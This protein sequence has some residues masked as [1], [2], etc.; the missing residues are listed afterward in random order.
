M[1]KTNWQDPK[2]SEVRSTHISGLQEAVGK[3]EESI[4][5]E[6]IAETNIPLS[7][8]YIAE[9]DRYRIFQAPEGKRNW[10]NSPAPVIKKN[11]S[12]IT[13]DFEIDYGGGAIVFTTPVLGTDTLT[14]DVTYTKK[15]EGKGLS[16]NDYT[17]AEKNK[18]AGIEADFEVHLADY[19][20]QVPYG[21][22]TG[23]ANTYAVTL[24]PAPSAYTDGMALA[25]KIN[26]DNTGA[27][28]IN[29]NGLGA[30]SI[31]KSNGN[32]VSSG[33]L[34]AGSIYTLRYNGTNFI[35]QGEGGEYGTATPDKVL[36]GYTIGTEE[37]IKTGTMPNH[38]SKTF[39]P[40]DTTQTS[41]AGYYSGVTVNPRPTLSGNATPD[42]VLAGRTFYNN[43]YTRRT[44][45]LVIPIP[46]SSVWTQRT[47]S[48]D[49]TYIQGVAYGNNMFVVVG[50]GGKLATSTDGITWTQRT[51]S[52][53]T[54]YIQDVAYG[55]NMWV[56]VGNSGKLATST[57]G[58]TWTQRT[59]S[60]SSTDIRGVAYG[61]NMFVVVGSSGKLATSTDGI[62]WTQRTS[63]FGTTR[64]WGVAYGNNMWVAVGESGKLATSTN[65][66][67]W[68]QRTS[69]FSSTTIY[70]VAYGNNTMWV[71][72]GESGKLAT[73]TDGITWTQRTSSFSSTDIR[74]VAYGNN[75]WVAVGE[76]GKLA[77]STDGITWT[78][79]TS[80]FDTT[81]RGV[82]YGNNMWVAVGE[83]GKLATLS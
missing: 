54:T 77:T 50:S 36:S 13:N 39:T 19:V 23:S 40:N 72:V 25:I 49:T 55:N 24:D 32:N 26:V 64:M 17:A 21:A 53:D 57:N 70:G 4:G 29:V 45:T 15:V 38:G 20:L 9:A 78:Q 83:S 79:R 73:S 3:I 44:G 69:S 35:L 10:L 18:L 12:T 62:T 67:T 41:G 16:T 27:S 58:I 61:N 28:T 63:S 2:T 46:Y 34:K 43:S 30:K 11:G 80:S 33:N 56:A 37:G 81:Y 75:M 14:A 1:A 31:K 65:G 42:Q 8:V 7:E 82:A 52:F 74:G 6:S 71:A 48:F 66:I 59:S 68:T 22:T 51:S 60:F 76:S 47:S 5:I